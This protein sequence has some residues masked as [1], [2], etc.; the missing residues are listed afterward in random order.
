MNA[1]FEGASPFSPFLKGSGFRVSTF[2]C[3]VQD[4]IISPNKSTKK[5]ENWEMSAQKQPEN[6]AKAFRLTEKVP[7]F[8]SCYF[9][10]NLRQGLLNTDASN[11]Q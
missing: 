5:P 1:S 2:A 3:G 9:I 7:L 4:V 8:P 11:A 6:C 10:K